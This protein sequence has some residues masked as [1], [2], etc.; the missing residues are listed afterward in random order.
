M[1]DIFQDISD[2]RALG[3]FGPGRVG[4]GR[5]IMEMGLGG[6]NKHFFFYEA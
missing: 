1:I 3:F 4:S 5:F 2:Q 6:E